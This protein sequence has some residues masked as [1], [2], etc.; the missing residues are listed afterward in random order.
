MSKILLLTAI[1]FLVTGM[2]LGRMS[3]EE[4]S[5]HF[6]TLSIIDSLKL[7]FKP[8]YYKQWF[9]P[10][11]YKYYISSIVCIYTG[12]FFSMLEKYLTE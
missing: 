1:I 2:I 7:M 4:R 11:G 12:L 6:P 5:A 9:N 10:L 8:A 3:W